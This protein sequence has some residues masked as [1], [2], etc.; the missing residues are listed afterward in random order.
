MGDFNWRGL[1]GNSLFMQNLKATL[2]DTNLTTA[3]DMNNE[4]ELARYPNLNR[5]PNMGMNS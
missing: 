4:R 3:P 5:Y 2:I 1:I